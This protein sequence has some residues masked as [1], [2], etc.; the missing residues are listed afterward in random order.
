MIGLKRYLMMD[1]PTP[2][3]LGAILVEPV[4]VDLLI[5][6]GTFGN[7]RRI[8]L[9]NTPINLKRIQA[10]QLQDQLGQYVEMQQM[11]LGLSVGALHA[12]G[13]P[14]VARMHTLGFG[15]FIRTCHS[16]YLWI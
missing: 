13:W 8:G 14:P 4:G 10:D 16:L 5:W 9:E 1:M 2:R 12:M 7:G 6:Q 3:Q 15:V 11:A